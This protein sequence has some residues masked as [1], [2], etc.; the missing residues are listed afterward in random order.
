M[1]PRPTRSDR[2]RI[3]FLAVFLL[4]GGIAVTPGA[5]HASV[6]EDED[7]LV[8]RSMSFS[9]PLL[10]AD[11]KRQSAASRGYSILGGVAAYGGAD[12]NVYR[13]PAD[14]EQNSRAWGT[15]SYLRSDLRFAADSR[16]ATTVT[17]RQARFSDHANVDANYVAIGNTFERSLRGAVDLELGLDASF[18]N[19]DAA[20]IHGAKYAQGYGY[21]R[22]GADALLSWEPRRG[23]RVRVLGELVSKNYEETPGFDSVDWTQWMTTLAYR[24]RV[25]PHHYL[26]A[27]YGTGRRAYEEELAGLRTG[28]E[29]PGNPAERHRYGDLGFAYWGRIQRRL[30]LNAAYDR[31]SK[32]D[33]FEAYESRSSD[34]LGVGV[35]VRVGSRV[36]VRVDAQREWRDY[37]NV[38]G[39]DG[40]NLAFSTG[41][42]SGGARVRLG[43]SLW[44]FGS[45]SRYERDSN[46]STGTTY[47][48]YHGTIT[49]LGTSAFF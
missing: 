23:H 17:W 26:T 16:L 48:D 43:S 47:R 6:D 2:S 34:E 8:G 33:L 22:F 24:V 31:V 12:D 35:G 9:V 38:P 14:S 15:W 20:N 41:E 36:E 3:P 4:L 19:D 46:K 10:V 40:R 44:L 29:L 21:R 28:E 45:L 18:K 27:S 42:V 32:N 7:E 5:V 49:R 37:A 39:D 1:Q 11:A 13:S 25:A 30:T